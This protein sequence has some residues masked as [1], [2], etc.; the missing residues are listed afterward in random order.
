MRHLYP[1]HHN[2]SFEKKKNFI[3]K[4]WAKNLSFY[5]NGFA[6]VNIC[7][8]LLSSTLLY[9]NHKPV[10]TYSNWK[11]VGDLMLIE[12]LFFVLMDTIR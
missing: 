10:Y 8:N 6:Q 4:Q 3:S 5:A 1:D 12:W 11:S 2:I 7:N 9:C